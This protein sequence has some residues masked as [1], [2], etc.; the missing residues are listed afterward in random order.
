M[1]RCHFAAAFHAAAF[2]DSSL[3][4][5]SSMPLRRFSFIRCCHFMIT[6]DAADAIIMIIVMIF[7]FR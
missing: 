3:I 7:R 5:S 1:P 2:F 6:L 4:I